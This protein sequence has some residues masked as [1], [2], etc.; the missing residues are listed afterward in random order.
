MNF[1]S[2]AQKHEGISG[3]DEY[4]PELNPVNGELKAL[5]MV[6]MEIRNF[7]L[8]K[9]TSEKAKWLANRLNREG[10]VFGTSAKIKNDNS[11]WLKW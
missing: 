7:R 9:A 8:D 1:N 6:P 4:R 5:K 3:H 10:L 11:L 2:V